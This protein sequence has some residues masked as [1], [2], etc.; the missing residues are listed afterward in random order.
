MI[1]GSWRSNHEI[2][3][4]INGYAID[5]IKRYLL[6]FTKWLLRKN[7]VSAYYF[8][9]LQASIIRLLLCKIWTLRRLKVYKAGVYDVAKYFLS[10]TYFK[11]TCSPYCLRFRICILIRFKILLRNHKTIFFRNSWNLNTSYMNIH[12]DASIFLTDTK[13]LQMC[14]YIYQYDYC[15]WQN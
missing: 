15:S 2:L 5:S 3:F 8:L 9:C 4:K 10:D 11:T 7:V 6:D 14:V 13:S 12:L 1:Q